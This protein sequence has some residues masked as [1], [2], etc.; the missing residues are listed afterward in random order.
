[1]GIGN[2]GVAAPGPKWADHFGGVSDKKDTT[3]TQMVQ[4]LGFISIGADPHD[5]AV[6][7]GTKLAL[8][9]LT[10][11]VFA[12]GVRRVGVGCHLVIDAPHLIA[13]QVL[14]HG[15]VFVERGFNPGVPLQWWRV[16][17]THIGDAPAVIAPFGVHA[18]LAPGMKRRVRTRGIDHVL[19]FDAVAA[20]WRFHLQGGDF[21]VLR[22]P[23]HA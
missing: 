7:V 22:K 21:I 10:H 13:H 2:A 15:A 16:L 11:H 23:H 5:V 12:A 20:G 17:E 8:Q 19:G 14:P 18:G 6:D 1:M 3:N 4:A 9:S